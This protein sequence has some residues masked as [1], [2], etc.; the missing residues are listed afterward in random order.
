MERKKEEAARVSKL[1]KENE[2]LRQRLKEERAA[3]ETERKAR[4]TA[5]AHYDVL[6]VR[7]R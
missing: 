3:K 1:E 7:F 4:V 6:S 2:K 5:E